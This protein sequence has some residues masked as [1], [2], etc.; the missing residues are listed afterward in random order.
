MNNYPNATSA[1]DLFHDA[2]VD[3]AVVANA[4]RVLL[5]HVPT[6]NYLYDLMSFN[7]KGIKGLLDDHPAGAIAEGKAVGFNISP[8]VATVPLQFWF[9]RNPGLALPLIALQYH[10]KIKITFCAKT[11][12][13]LAAFGATG[14]PTDAQLWADY[15]Y[16]DTDERCRFAQVSHEYSIEQLQ[17]E[18]GK[19]N[20]FYR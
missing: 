12:L 2:L 5:V 7:H 18:T 19:V 14:F 16:L 17:L 20:Q 11:I 9:N 10:I 1:K 13:L 3:G 8:K 4:P 15:I 6:S